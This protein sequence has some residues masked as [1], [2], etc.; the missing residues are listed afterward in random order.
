MGESG[1]GPITSSVSPTQL[2]LTLAVGN[3][4]YRAPNGN[5]TT[6][7]VPAEVKMCP[8]GYFACTINPSH[9]IPQAAICDKKPD[10][11]DNSDE[12]KCRKSLI[13]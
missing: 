10:C 8:L 11:E 9:C 2:F 13:V 7:P 4:T 3:P 6:N 12:Q 1:L 5:H